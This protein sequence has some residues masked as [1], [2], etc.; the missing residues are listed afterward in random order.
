MSLFQLLYTSMPFFLFAYLAHTFY[1]TNNFKDRRGPV[2]F[3]PASFYIK[4]INFYG[5]GIEI[6]AGFWPVGITEE[7]FGSIMS[8]F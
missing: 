6:W 3:F 7:N 4:N 5:T 2:P 1:V 8:N